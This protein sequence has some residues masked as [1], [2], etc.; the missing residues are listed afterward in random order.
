[1]S[2][3]FDG[4]AARL[5]VRRV[6]RFRGDCRENQRCQEPLILRHF[7]FIL[8]IRGAMNQEQWP[9]FPSFGPE[10]HFIGKTTHSAK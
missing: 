9:R 6:P 8:P 7:L 4:G 5:S 10:G 3:P 1:V 2:D